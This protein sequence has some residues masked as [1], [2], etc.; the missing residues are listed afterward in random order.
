LSFIG[1]RAVAEERKL[2][3]FKM[4]MVKIMTRV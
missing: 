2:W 3:R 4:K 1:C